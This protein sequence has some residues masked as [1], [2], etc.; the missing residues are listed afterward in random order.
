MG[1]VW[2]PSKAA[3][4]LRKHGIHFADAELVLF[5]PA[6]IPLDDPSATGEQR[7]G[8]PGTDAAAR[9]LAV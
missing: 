8:S 6:A 7:P 3:A 5:D 2:D 1:A 4:N 9:A